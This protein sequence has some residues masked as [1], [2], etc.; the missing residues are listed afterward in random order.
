MVGYQLNL[1]L[2]KSLE[3]VDYYQYFFLLN[4]KHM[5]YQIACLSAN[6]PENILRNCVIVVK[7][8][9]YQFLLLLPRVN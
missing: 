1:N 8:A 5:T 6:K 7:P 9:N 4:V 3:M 2:C